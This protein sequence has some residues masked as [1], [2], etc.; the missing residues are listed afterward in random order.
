MLIKIS[1]FG[2]VVRELPRA[3]R[4]NPE[5][6]RGSGEPILC[7]SRGEHLLAGRRIA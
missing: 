4:Q 5:E 6:I 2:S 7:Y 3:R 1:R